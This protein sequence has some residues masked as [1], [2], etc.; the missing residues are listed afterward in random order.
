MIL[1]F[2][3]GYFSETYVSQERILQL[4]LY[5]PVNFNVHISLYVCYLINELLP[6]PVALMQLAC[7]ISLG[8]SCS[9]S[10]SGK[11]LGRGFASCFSCIE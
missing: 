1:Q 8:V 5:F 11:R 2:I 6:T 9:F 4:N 10:E 7:L 3:L